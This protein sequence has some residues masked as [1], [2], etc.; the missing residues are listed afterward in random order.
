MVEDPG[1]PD[2]PRSGRSC[3]SRSPSRPAVCPQ[4]EPGTLPCSSTLRRLARLAILFSNRVVKISMN[5]CTD[6]FC[7]LYRPAFLDRALAQ[8]ALDLIA[9]RALQLCLCVRRHARPKVGAQSRGPAARQTIA[10]FPGQPR[11]RRI[12]MREYYKRLAQRELLHE[13]GSKTFSCVYFIHAVQLQIY[14]EDMSVRMISYS[15]K[16]RGWPAGNFMTRNRIQRETI[17]IQGYT[18]RTG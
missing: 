10:R 7:L 16:R 17:R 6:V 4:N 2:F 9:A 15:L 3:I 12:R 11:M 13:R 1:S 8:T 5:K 18:S 14:S